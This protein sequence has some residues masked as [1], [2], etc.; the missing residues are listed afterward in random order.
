M[1]KATL[2][3]TTFN[4]GRLIGSEFQ[5]IIIKVGAWQCP[6]RYGTGG[7]ENSTS[8]SKGKQEKTGSQKARM[9]V[10]KPMPTVTHLLQQGHIS[11]IATPWVKH[12][13]T[14]TFHSLAPIGLFKHM[15]LW[16]PCLA[17]A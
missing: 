16:E 15:S 1:T 3:K 5:F 13:Q 14:I 8:S 17:I 9:R 7:A 6:D 2:T 10:L 12:I 11:N 4:W